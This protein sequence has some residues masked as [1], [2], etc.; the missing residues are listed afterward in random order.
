MCIRDSDKG[1][2][3]AASGKH[4]DM[5][6]A[7]AL[8]L[9]GMDQIEQVQEERQAQKP[10]NI[11]EMLQFELS[12]GSLYR[13]SQDIFACEEQDFEDGPLSFSS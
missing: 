3:E 8:A 10:R 12:T 11:E 4:D 6:F 9:I 13:E 2:P 7:T 1:K 5:V